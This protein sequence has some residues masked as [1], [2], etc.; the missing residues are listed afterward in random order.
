[1]DASLLN[2]WTQENNILMKEWKRKNSHV[3]G[4][5]SVKGKC[6]K[7]ML[8]LL[9]TIQGIPAVSELVELELTAAY[10]TLVLSFNFSTLIDVQQILSS[11][12]HRAL[13]AVGCQESSRDPAALWRI[14][15]Q[16]FRNTTPLL[17]LHGLLCVQWAL[18]L[19]S[20]QMD[21]IHHLLKDATQG[22]K[23]APSPSQNL[24]EAIKKLRLADNNNSN[25]LTAMTV[26]EF[27]DLLHICTAIAEG[28]E[29]MRLE[30][31]STALVSMLGATSLPAPR[32]LLAR[33]HTLTG[34]TYAKLGQPQSALQSYRKALEVDFGCRTALY[35]SA[36][37]YR[38]LKTTQAE[39][40]ALR[41]LHAALIQ[42][43]E[44]KTV[45][46]GATPISPDVL[47]RS[48]Y[49]DAI[50]AVPSAQLV[51]HSLAHTCVLHDRVSEA[52]ELYLDLM[53]S[54]QSEIAQPVFTEGDV[55]L[56]RIPVVYLEAA[57][58]LL[59]AKRAW[60]AIA[61]C[62]E[63]ISKTAN[64]I[65]EKQNAFDLSEEQIIFSMEGPSKSVKRER[66]EYV[67]WGS[68]AHYLLGLAYSNMK[69]TKE[70]VTNFTR[71]LNCLA[72]VSIKNAGPCAEEQGDGAVKVKVLARLRGLALAGR[73]LSFMERGQFK[74]ALRD[75]KLSL[76]SVTDTQIINLGLV[77][78]FRRLGRQDE[79]LVCWREL[80]RPSEA[81][82]SGHLP[83]YLQTF[84]H[85]SV[86]FDTSDL[87][88]VMRDAF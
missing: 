83:L 81:V 68:A 88:K 55:S 62:E 28:L 50:L 51:L 23:E 42:S 29:H 19:A 63:V 38:K 44:E 65:P 14:T 49:M 6:H 57:F 22:V 34:V 74:E 20:C 61:V 75:L 77:E 31:S 16:C 72:K 33:V 40:E 36:L 25:L 17:C 67:L 18:W 56:P 5:E 43:S 64:L 7:G 70:A 35:Q 82:S 80:Q 3:G 46:V 1:M 69:D 86:S 13:E 39:M 21:S 32:A 2:K 11:T 52:V 79:A 37:V 60:D 41:L 78:V 15:L 48:Q 45:D 9:Q 54:L 10:N 12:L 59:K 66:L 27:L 8:K 58:T 71:S 76:H 26:R 73:G 47:L 30:D 84:P 87:D 4:K 24:H 53:S 85:V